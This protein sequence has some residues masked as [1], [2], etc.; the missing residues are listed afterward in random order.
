MGEEE[1]VTTS[2]C[3]AAPSVKVTEREGTSVSREFFLS[4]SVCLHMC[5]RRGGGGGWRRGVRPPPQPESI[6]NTRKSPSQPYSHSPA[7]HLCPPNNN[8]VNNSINNDHK[9]CNPQFLVTYS[10]PG[11]VCSM[12]FT[13]SNSCSSQE[14]L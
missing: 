10:G 13:Y 9:N 1:Q 7:S 3:V 11:T 14:Y 2:E 6:Y 8:N 5:W 4:N 12:S